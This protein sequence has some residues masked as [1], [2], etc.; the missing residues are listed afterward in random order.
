MRL[1]FCVTSE[2][3]GRLCEDGGERGRARRA[4]GDEKMCGTMD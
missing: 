4:T 3:R 1:R 2:T